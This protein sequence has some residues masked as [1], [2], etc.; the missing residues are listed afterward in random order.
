MA[1][2]DRMAD[3]GFVF[4]ND[5]DKNPTQYYVG[6]LCYVMHDVWDEVCKLT[7][8]DDKT[9]INGRVQLKDGREIF[10]YSTTYGDG[11]YPDNEGRR[12]L[13]D[14]GTIGAIR[15]EDIH[16]PAGKELIASGCKYAHVVEM[17]NPLTEKVCSN[18]N[19]AILLGEVCVYT[20]N[21]DDEWEDA[22]EE[23]E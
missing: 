7:Y 6:D 9:E 11:E 12:Y 2:Q 13:V 8:P 16:D 22:E 10:I 17:S 21:D 15:V 5:A 4:V 1:I 19:G 14:S 18:F 20:N 3:T 23:A